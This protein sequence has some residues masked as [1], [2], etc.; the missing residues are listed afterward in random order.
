VRKIALFVL[1]FVCFA[2]CFAANIYNTQVD[3]AERNFKEGNFSK[4]IEIYESLIKIEKIQDPYIY[5]NLSNAYYRN[6]DLGKAILNIEKAFKLAP[7]DKEIKSNMK[8]LYTLVGHDKEQNIKDIVLKCFTLNEITI[9]TSILLILFF[10]AVS[11]FIIKK[12]LIFKNFV[13]FLLF[14][15]FF[16]ISI[17][18]LKACQEFTLKEA[19]IL[20][21]ASVRS[22]PG[23]NNPE[24]F[25]ISEGKLVNIVAR[26]GHWVNIRFKSKGED[27]IGWIPNNDIGTINE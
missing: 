23:E 25:S 3:N 19:V 2:F 26:N 4:T 8:F 1:L 6:G 24:I 5:Y 9:A 14:F 16:C 18:T 10:A 17:L 20:A 13:L 15:L 22:G 12:N 21:S 7:R 27:F 11:L